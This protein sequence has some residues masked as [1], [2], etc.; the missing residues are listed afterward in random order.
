MVYPRDDKIDAVER[1][2]RATQLAKENL[3]CAEQRKRD[4]ILQRATE[5]GKQQKM[6]EENA[7]GMYDACVSS[8]QVAIEK[9]RHLEE[10]W[11]K[12]AEEKL[13]QDHEDKPW[14]LEHRRRVLGYGKLK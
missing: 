14:L 5:Q 2:R 3:A 4:E 7:R 8:H 11:A 10:E 13:V 9:R 6:L 12:A 1:R